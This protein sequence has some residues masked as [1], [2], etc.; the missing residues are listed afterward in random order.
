[1]EKKIKI[2]TMTREERSY[3]IAFMK[4]GFTLTLKEVEEATGLNK[5]EIL[6]KLETLG[7]IAPWD[8]NPIYKFA[9]KQDE[10]PVPYTVKSC[11]YTKGGSKN[12]GKGTLWLFKPYVVN[13]LLDQEPELET[14]ETVYVLTEEE[15][16]QLTNRS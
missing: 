1:M 3:A 11:K 12:Y 13:I 6:T 5:D 10:Q 15:Y 16:E 4:Y 2:P 9:V 7:Y 14:W 8:K